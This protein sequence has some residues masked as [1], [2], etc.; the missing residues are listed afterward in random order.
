[1]REKAPSTIPLKKKSDESELCHTSTMSGVSDDR[2]SWLAEHVLPH[3][4]GLRA[5]LAQRRVVDLDVNDIVQETYAV[6]A[7]LKSVNH[8]RNPRT[9]LYSVA[10]SIILQHL[11]RQRIVRIEAM[12]DVEHLGIYSEEHTPEEALSDFQELRFLAQLIAGLPR[13]CGEAF[14]LR[15]IEG[16]S[17]REIAGRMRIAES[18][19]E[20]HIGKALRLLMAAMRES[21]TVGAQNLTQTPV[22]PIR[23][24]IE[25]RSDE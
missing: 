1:M 22:S 17:Q 13:K 21:S 20:K 25:R 24:K 8:I 3:E 11:R 23:Q 12:A 15:K 9:Y 2:A 7:E 6:L 5:W 4:R 18:T 10:Q 14:T 16:L 19:V